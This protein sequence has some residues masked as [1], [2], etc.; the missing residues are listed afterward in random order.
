MIS[1][2]IENNVD[3]SHIKMIYMFKDLDSNTVVNFKSFIEQIID[4]PC[5]LNLVIVNRC[6][7][8]KRGV[9]SKFDSVKF[10]DND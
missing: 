6:D 9:L 2:A 5:E 7:Y 10:I 4:S 3:S 1:K 8:P